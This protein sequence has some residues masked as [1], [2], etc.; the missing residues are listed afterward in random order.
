MSIFLIAWQQWKL[1]KQKRQFLLNNTSTVWPVYFFRGPGT[2]VPESTT[3]TSTCLVT[4]WHSYTRAHKTAEAIQTLNMLILNSWSL[5]WI[6]FPHTPVLIEKFSPPY[7]LVRPLLYTYSIIP[8]L[9]SKSL[10]KN[11]VANENFD[12]DLTFFHDKSTSNFHIFMT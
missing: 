4:P 5:L 1:L 2:S 6:N 12:H 3:A 9:T 10:E 8:F 11:G 7:W